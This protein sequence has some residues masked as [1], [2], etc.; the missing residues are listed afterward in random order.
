MTR[1]RYYYGHTCEELPQR[2]RKHNAN[3]KG[4]TGTN[5]DWKIVYFEKYPIK[6]QAYKREREVK[7]WKS[8]KR[9]QALIKNGSAHPD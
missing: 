3:H 2:L 8:S 9:V 6:E 7:A 5:P 4:F 1:N